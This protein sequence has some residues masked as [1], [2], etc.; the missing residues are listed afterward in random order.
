[1]PL[2]D[3][4]LF[5]IKFVEAVEKYK[6]LYDTT[7]PQ[8]FSKDEQDKAW[9]CIAETFC[10]TG[11]ECKSRWKH[12]RGGLTRYIKKRQGKS[13]QGAKS[14]RQFYLWDVMQFVLPFLKS[15]IQTGTLPTPSP[16]DDSEDP[17]DVEDDDVDPKNPVCE[18]CLEG[19]ETP[20]TTKNHPSLP[21]FATSS[22][23][24]RKRV[25]DDPFERTVADFISKKSGGESEN[26]DFQFFKSLLPDVAGFSGSQKRRF[27]IKVLELIDEICNEGSVS[28]SSSVSALN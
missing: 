4:E 6:C 21:S 18:A 28:R 5:N 13:G 2:P 17:D 24:G 1:M 9:N 22:K 3:N 19:L 26:P 23:R 7:S 11:T 25:A 27:K 16:A 10:S 12:L 15:R 20:R 14:I 8:Y